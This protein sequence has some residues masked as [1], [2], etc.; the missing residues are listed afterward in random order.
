MDKSD[1]HIQI[2]QQVYSNLFMK[3]FFLPFHRQKYRSSLYHVYTKSM[4]KRKKHGPGIEKVQR[5]F[6]IKVCYKL[7]LL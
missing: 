3:C 1:I 2:Y 7:N 4:Q 5:R 6:V